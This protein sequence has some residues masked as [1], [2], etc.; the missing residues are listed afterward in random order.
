MKLSRSSLLNPTKK[1]DPD[2]KCVLRSKPRPKRKKWYRVILPS[3][4][5]VTH[6][7]VR[8]SMDT[9]GAVNSGCWHINLVN[10]HSLHMSIS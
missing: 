6:K 4:T 3:T 1:R 2:P 8:K 9:K 10:M 5:L 7:N